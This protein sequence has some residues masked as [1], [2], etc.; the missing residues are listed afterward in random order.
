MFKN[1]F[2][3]LFSKPTVSAIDLKAKLKVAERQRNAARRRLEAERATT[4]TIFDR[5]VE[6]REEGDNTSFQIVYGEYRQRQE[7]IKLLEREIHEGHLTV[8]ILQ[9][10]VRAAEEGEKKGSGKINLREALGLAKDANIETALQILAA[11]QEELHEKAQEFLE[12][13][14]DVL[15]DMPAFTPEN[16][17]GMKGL[18]EDIDMLIDAKQSGDLSLLETERKRA[19]DKLDEEKG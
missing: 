17:P 10:A 9:R 19:K 11:E 18:M 6:A 8:T 13:T 15:A 4:E 12:D 16:D 5:M 3:R 7:K 14:E 1:F 2:K